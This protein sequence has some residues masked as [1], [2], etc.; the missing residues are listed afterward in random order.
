MAERSHGSSNTQGGQEKSRREI[1]RST[2]RAW[3][4]LDEQ[5][6]RGSEEESQSFPIPMLGENKPSGL[7]ENILLWVVRDVGTWLGAMIQNKPLAL[8][9]P[10]FLVGCQKHL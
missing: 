3:A 1:L 5:L 6:L 9:I 4:R 2:K 7:S 10:V 8:K